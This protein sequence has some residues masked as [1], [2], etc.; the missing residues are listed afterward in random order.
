MRIVIVSDAWYPQINGVVRALDRTRELLEARGHGVTIIGPDRFRTVPMPTYQEIRLALTRPRSVGA[1]I[2]ACDPDAVHVATEG[3]LGWCARSWLRTHGLP[4]TTSF[5]TMFPSS[6]KVRSGIPER[7]SWAVIRRFHAA[8][9]ATMVSTA[10]LQTILE[11][12]GFERVALGPRRRHDL[13][14]LPGVDLRARDH[15]CSTSVASHRR[16]G[17]KTS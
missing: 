14:P 11:N 4:F 7:W 13:R 8:A 5:H 16:S 10:T 12:R 1:Q 6:V 15:T 17:S 2:A 3:P 9:E